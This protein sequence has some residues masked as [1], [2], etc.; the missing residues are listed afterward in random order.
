M[1]TDGWLDP[2]NWSGKFTPPTPDDLEYLQT[3]FGV[4]HER[5]IGVEEFLPWV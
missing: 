4:V 1:K 2:A 3:P 5:H